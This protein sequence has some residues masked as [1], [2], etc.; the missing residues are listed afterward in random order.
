MSFSIH[1]KKELAAE[2]NKRRH[3]QI[4]ELAAMTSFLGQLF[5]RAD[6]RC[7]LYVQTENAS[8]ARKYAALLKRCFHIHAEVSVRCCHTDSGYFSHSRSYCVYISSTEDVLHMLDAFKLLSPAHTPELI[9]TLIH[10]LLIQKSCCRRAFLRGAFLAAGSMSDPNKSYHLEFVCSDESKAAQLQQILNSFDLHA[11]TVL[12]KKQYVVYI[13]EGEQI[14][15]LL[16]LTEA[17]IALMEFENIRIRREIANKIN[18]QTNC[19]VANSQKTV[20]ASAKQRE[21][22]ELIERVKGLASL[23]QPLYEIAVLRLEHPDVSIKELGEMLT[24]PVGKSGVNHRLRKLNQIA[25]QIR[26]TE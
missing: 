21:D 11:K 16:G 19:D 14:T 6:G 3:C 26:G 20:S 1:I 2:H 12:R 17:H 25:N 13:K 8:A 18:R 7:T 24:P 23:S 9:D 5:V 22:I 4:A 10:P 15:T